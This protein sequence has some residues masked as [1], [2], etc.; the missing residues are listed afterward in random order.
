MKIIFFRN[1]C[2]ILNCY[3]IY[4]PFLS[5]T[6]AA[7]NL[8]GV[9]PFLYQQMSVNF[10]LYLNDW[11]YTDRTRDEQTV[12]RM[13]DVA[14]PKSSED[15]GKSGR[16]IP[17]IQIEKKGELR[18]C[19]DL[20]RKVNHNYRYKDVSLSLQQW[21]D[22]FLK[23]EY[24][25][26]GHFVWQIHLNN[27]LIHQVYDSE[28]QTYT[29]VNVYAISGIGKFPVANGNIRNLQIITGQVFLF[30]QLSIMRD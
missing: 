17:I 21:H 28:P 24:T 4:F 9:L 20:G 30:C 10:S 5:V 13:T 12:F 18:V 1:T 25:N 2:T 27:D 23:M 15:W 19:M 3:F 14:D 22:L 16:R 6:I 11:S 26:D 7:N 8:I 29:N